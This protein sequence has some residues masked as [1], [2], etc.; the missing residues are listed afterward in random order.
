AQFRHRNAALSLAQHRHDLRLG[1]SGFS[2]SNLLSSRYE[3]ILLP[4]PLTTGR[5]TVGSLRFQ[6]RCR[7]NVNQRSLR[8]VLR[9]RRL[10]R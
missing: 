4:N 8:G 1:K 9:Q 10:P 3:K 5:I 2:Y 6:K 7:R